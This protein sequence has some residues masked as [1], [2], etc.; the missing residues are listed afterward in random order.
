MAIT[1]GVHHVGLSVTNLGATK[2]FFV[3]I[4][5]FEVL[6]YVEGDH[7]F[8]TDGTT[9]ITL[10]PT[11]EV[12]VEVKTAGLHHIAFEV[13]SLAVLRKIEERMKQNNIRLQFNGIGEQGYG[14]T[15]LFCYG[16]SGI[17]IEFST[18]EKHSSQDIPN[19]GGC[20]V[21]D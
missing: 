10:W 15:S 6:E 12:E 3:E 1:K 4:L 2:D 18:L 16:P 7:A 9:M 5:E 8:V 19:I 11:A 13:E 17:R 21:L 14:L 20:G